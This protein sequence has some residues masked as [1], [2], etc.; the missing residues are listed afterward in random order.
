MSNNI[1]YNSLF[2]G[3]HRPEIDGLRAVAILAVIIYHFNKNILPNGYLGVDIFFV[4]SGYV[5]TSS[6]LKRKSENFFDFLFQFYERRVKRLIPGLLFF[7]LVNSILI[8][9]INPL[10]RLSIK[11]GIASLFGVSNIYLYISSIDYFSQSN[12]LNVFANTW[13]LGLEEQFYLLFPFIFWFSGLGKNREKGLNIFLY[14]VTSLTLAS[15][16]IFIYFSQSNPSAAY[17]LLPS[18][19][20][21]I[22]IGSLIFIYSSKGN[23]LIKKLENI[24][25]LFV[26][27]IIIL[28]LLIPIQSKLSLHILTVVFSCI[29]ICGLKKGTIVHRFLTLKKIIYL[30]L[31]SYSLYL[32]HWSILVISKW[33]IGVHWWSLPIQA[34][35]IIT[36]SIFSYQ[37]IELPLRKSLWFIYP[38]KNLVLG[39]FS[40]LTA[41]LSLFLLGKPFR[42]TFY[43]GNQN[44]NTTYLGTRPINYKGEFTGQVSEI[45]D[46]T[47]GE[48]DILNSD[49]SLTDYFIKNCFW[50]HDTNASMIALIGDSH[51]L[52]LFPMVEKFA[53]E[54]DVKIFS[55]S[56][57]GCAF[58]AQGVTTRFGCNRVM[59]SVENFI[60]SEFSKNKGGLIFTSSNLVSHFGY[61]GKHR[62]QFKKNSDGSKESVDL[63]LKDFINALKR[64][65]E[66]LKI[67]D[68]K[69]VI[70]APIPNH[71]NFRLEICNVQWFRPRNLLS[72]YCTKTDKNY[73]LGKRAHIMEALKR[74]V[75]NSSHLFLYDPYNVL[76]DESYCYPERNGIFLYNDDNHLNYLGA[77]FIYNDFLNFLYKNQLLT[78]GSR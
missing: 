61:D 35:F 59:E 58:P 74:L 48:R 15:L 65:E 29:L 27:L 26:L 11:T 45:C 68:S 64:I 62:K 13:S 24:P 77:N 72:D 47:G 16:I 19:L 23:L 2:S 17:F 20:W 51:S 50:K 37:F 69:M 55:H 38:I 10:P 32:W 73:L 36:I 25:S 44:I 63:N 60:F 34:L 4:I 1:I 12:E 57:G 76:C 56:R 7:I 53:Q 6:L 67:V 39:V 42:G 49:N 22:S 30:G 18:R 43:I 3:K 71:K 8:C 46:S 21:E 9:L 33:T 41:A 40:I 5:I 14:I 31:V 54:I 66:K 78:S 52:S 70:F 75:K 28:L